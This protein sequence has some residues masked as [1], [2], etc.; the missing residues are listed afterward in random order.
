MYCILFHEVSLFLIKS[1]NI[2]PVYRYNSESDNVCVEMTFSKNQNLNFWVNPGVSIVKEYYNMAKHVLGNVNRTPAQSPLGH[3]N[4]HRCPLGFINLLFAENRLNSSSKSS[5][6]S[7]LQ[8]VWLL[9]INLASLGPNLALRSPT[10]I[11]K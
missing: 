3:S 9:Y 7:P 2:L 11:T 1:H 10:I 6:Y 8:L 5:K 4:V